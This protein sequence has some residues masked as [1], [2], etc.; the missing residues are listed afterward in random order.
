M[1]TLKIRHIAAVLLCVFAGYLLLP[2]EAIA[3][4]SI[5]LNHSHCLTVTAIYDK[6]PISGMRFDAYLISTADERGELTVIDSYQDYADDLDIRGKNDE[7]WQ[8]MA[9]TLA[10]E[11][12]LDNSLKPSRSVETDAEGKAVFTDIPMG[13]YL[14]MGNGV[15]KDGYVYSTSPFFIMIPEQ[16][17]SSNTWNY[18]VVANAKPG[19]E[20]E[21]A[22]YEV[23]KVWKDDC[24]KDQRPQSITI[25]LICDGYVYDTITLPY[26]GTWSYT[27]KDLETNHQWTVE[28]KKEAGYQN[29]DIQQEGNT[30]IVTNTCNKPTNPTVPGKPTLPQTGQL[31]WP[32]PL[33]MAAG[34]L[35]VVIGQILRRG[36]R[37]EK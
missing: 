28:E 4:G 34:L 29:P 15:V 22:D 17:L 8:A 16:D 14:I 30:F 26:N 13:L 35:F 25:A 3:A 10:R 7:R 24:H 6:I 21:R 12:M 23:I 33:M 11:I 36:A 19:R 32:V 5:D 1:K 37:D 18:D 27:W 2:M 31:W 9:Q 20:S